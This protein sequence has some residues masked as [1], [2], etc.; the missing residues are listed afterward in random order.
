MLVSKGNES[1]RI[2]KLNNTKELWH[3]SAFGPLPKA[4]RRGVSEGLGNESSEG[5]S[6]PPLPSTKFVS[7]PMASRQKRKRRTHQKERTRRRS[8][9]C[10]RRAQGVRYPAGVPRTGRGRE[11]VPFMIL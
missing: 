3:V 10:W 11:K 1:R 5:L 4:W 7:L 9:F 6:H 8:T 2:L